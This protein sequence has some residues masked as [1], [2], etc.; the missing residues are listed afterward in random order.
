M[1]IVDNVAAML[2]NS[3]AAVTYGTATAGNKHPVP[4]AVPGSG[5]SAFT[6][7]GFRSD[8]I[9]NLDPV[10]GYNAAGWIHDGT[11]WIER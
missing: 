9:E 10:N 2:A 1:L 7:T 4:V 3:G 5:A 8:I 6:I 11:N